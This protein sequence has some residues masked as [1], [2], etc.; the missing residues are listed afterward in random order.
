MRPEN[1]YELNASAGMRVAVRSS[2]KVVATA[3]SNVKP[4][5]GLSSRKRTARLSG[6][7]IA[8]KSLHDVVHDDAHRAPAICQLPRA[9]SPR[10]GRE[11]AWVQ[12]PGLLAL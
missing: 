7:S 4:V 11:H 12:E 6:A 2:V 5:E 8:T 3:L 10:P 9:R 1:E